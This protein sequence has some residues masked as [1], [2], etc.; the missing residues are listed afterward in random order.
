MK[1][2]KDRY[3]MFSGI[4]FKNYGWEIAS[5]GSDYESNIGI[6]VN[7][8]T[9]DGFTKPIIKGVRHNTITF[10][11]TFVKTNGS[12]LSN[13]TNR[14]WDKLCELLYFNEPRDLVV[15]SRIYRGFFL[16]GTEW[17]NGSKGYA[18]FDFQMTT[19]YVLSP[20]IIHNFEIKNG[21]PYEFTINNKSNVKHEM[22]YPDIEFET[23][24]SN[25]KQISIYN[26]TNNQSISL[27]GLNYKSWNQ[28]SNIP[29]RYLIS[30]ER[31]LISREGI[32]AYL[33]EQF[34]NSNIWEWINLV[35]GKN[36]IKIVC[37]G[38]KGQFRYQEKHTFR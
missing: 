11:I 37:Q 32:N 18:T 30:N 31:K 8:D 4:K 17:Y 10:P 26:L 23:T 29:L 15:G 5:I 34:S 27:S 16:K 21:E 19:P 6:N 28:Y 25:Y 3:C 38:C 12:S 2:I 1:Q 36:K 9:E 7:V 14:D 24:K 20:V 13:I 22:C 35:N 33:T